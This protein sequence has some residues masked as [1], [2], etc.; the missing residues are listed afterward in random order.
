MRYNVTDVTSLQDL[1]V[2][3]NDFMGGG[4]AYGIILSVWAISFY[5]LN[6]W[7]NDEAF[8]ASTWSAW[9]TSGI[10]A[11]LDIIE[12]SFSILLLVG[13]LLLTAY[14]YASNP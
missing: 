14:S 10:L 8:V 2:H 11:L 9:L 1:F 6:D 5:A 12:P 7:P 4:F 13:V 3:S